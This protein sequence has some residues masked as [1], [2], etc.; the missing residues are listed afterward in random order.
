MNHA[1]TDRLRAYQDRRL[2]ALVRFA[3]VRSPFY[4]RWFRESGIDPASIR[5]VDDLP[6]L[7]LLDRAQLAGDPGSFLTYPRKAVW[8]A[9]STGTSG[10]VVTVYR[11]LGSSIYEMCALERQWGWFG[12]S[13]DPRRITLRGSDTADRGGALA[14]ARP[15]TG[16]LLVSSFHLEADRLPD[17]LA[18]MRAHRPVAVEG[19]PS[20]LVRLASLMVEAGEHF[21]VRGVITSSEMVGAHERALFADVFGGPLIDH[22]GQTERV[23]MAGT[24]EHGSTHWFDDYGIVEL[25]PVPGAGGRHEIVGTALHNWAFPLLRYRTGDE[26]TAAPPSVCP[27]GRP[28]RRLGTLDGRVEDAFTAADGRFVPLP[29][30]LVKDLVGLREVQVAQRVPGE[31]EFRMVPGPDVDRAAVRARAVA[32]VERFV[33]PGQVVTF[34]EMDRVPRSAT[35][36]VRPAVREP[37]T[38]EDVTVD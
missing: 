11:S 24:C 14:V 1:N 25:I 33:G 20:S 15:G 32:N 10:T 28:F 37:M 12:L 8:P 16:Q 5:T 29:H 35:G 23:A 30:S 13:R 9:R 31:F 4:R 18:A 2:R 38:G 21:P 17:I 3:A 22:Y 6:Q 36:K 27:C 34:R 19:W 26:V 7:P